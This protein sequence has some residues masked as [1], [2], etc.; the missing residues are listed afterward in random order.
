MW[1]LLA[2]VALLAGA[3]ARAAAAEAAKPPNVLLIVVESFRRDHAGCY[4]YGRDTTPAIDGLA[5]EGFRFDQAIAPSSW[6]MP[7]LAGLFASAPAAVHGVRAA[8]NCVSTEV[9]TLAGELRYN[10]YQTAGIM[11]NPMLHRSFG[12]GAGFDYYDDYTIPFGAGAD[13]LDAGKRAATANDAVTGD[14]VTRLAANWLQKSRDK[15]RPF[16]LYA[17]YFDPHYDYVPPPPYDRMFTDPDY[18]GKAGTWVAGNRGLILPGLLCHLYGSGV[19]A[20][21]D[22][23]S[24]LRIS[25]DP[26]RCGRGH[27]GAAGALCLSV[28]P[29]RLPLQADR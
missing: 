25:L 22:S 4:G 1:K 28:V 18:R 2:F 26:V 5:K 11:S 24:L 27:D 20:P 15:D 9:A 21:A 23:P 7:S 8:T 14:A 12:F 19:R 10:G 3:S 13:L 6:T 29:G 17:F 16:F